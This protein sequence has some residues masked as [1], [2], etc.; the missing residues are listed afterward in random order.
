M[1]STKMPHRTPDWADRTKR[2]DMQADLPR[3]PSRI[4]RKSSGLY[5]VPRLLAVRRTGCPK[6][7]QG[8]VHRFVASC[9]FRLSLCCPLQPEEDRSSRRGRS[10]WT[11]ERMQRLVRLHLPRPRITHPYLNRRFHARLKAAAV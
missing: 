11:W 6:G 10:K 3:T 8:T 7:Q 5:G 4:E 1:L 2:N 9:Q